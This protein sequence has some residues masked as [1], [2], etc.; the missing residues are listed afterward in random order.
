MHRRCHEND[1]ILQI[2]RW[3][4][5]PTKTCFF[6]SCRCRRG[7]KFSFAQLKPTLSLKTKVLKTL[8]HPLKPLTWRGS[9]SGAGHFDCHNSHPFSGHSPDIFGNL[10]CAPGIVPL[11]KMDSQSK[12]AL[13]QRVVSDLDSVSSLNTQ[14]EESGSEYEASFLKSLHNQI[15]QLLHLCF[16]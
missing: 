6:E 9:F 1:G 8:S 7:L 11:G 12:F 3:D 4:P 16:I 14:A 10:N 2:R 15:V 13:G 5:G